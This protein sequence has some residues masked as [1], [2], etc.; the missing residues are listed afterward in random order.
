[1]KNV[2]MTVDGDKLVIVVDLKQEFGLSSSGKSITIASTEGNVAVPQ[3]E[4]VK[5]GLNIYKPRPRQ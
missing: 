1:M 5:I 2:E 4:D 3:R